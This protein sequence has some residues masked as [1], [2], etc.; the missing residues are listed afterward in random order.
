MGTSLS[1]ATYLR[2]VLGQGVEGHAEFRVDLGDGL[3][4]DV[5]PAALAPVFGLHQSSGQVVGVPAREDDDALAGGAVALGLEARA[6]GGGVVVP[7]AVAQEH[8]VGVFSTFEGVVD[9]EEVGRAARGG[10]AQADA[11]VCAVD[12][13]A[14]DVGGAAVGAELEVG[15]GLG[16]EGVFDDLAYLA[17]E[18]D[19][20]L[21]VV[22]AAHDVAAGVAGHEVAGEHDAAGFGLAEARGHGD[23]QVLFFDVVLLEAV[24][25]FDQLALEGRVFSFWE[26][27]VHEALEGLTGGL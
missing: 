25:G 7:D 20:Q 22:A 13:C 21:V 9:D 5:L 16:C 1:F 2:I 26:V 17:S 15:E 8:R 11:E 12:F 3:E 19:G 6:E 24:E 4:V 18:V 23:E 14:P 10:A 27:Q